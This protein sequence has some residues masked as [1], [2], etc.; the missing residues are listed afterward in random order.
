MK[1]IGEQGQTVSHDA[2]DDLHYRYEDIQNRSQQQ[3]SVPAISHFMVMMA[4]M[5]NILIFNAV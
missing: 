1:G 2:T 3:A 4:H 5:S